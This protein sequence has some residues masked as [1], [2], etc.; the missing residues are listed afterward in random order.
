MCS[1]VGLRWPLV[2]CGCIIIFVFDSEGGSTVAVTV[3]LS[4]SVLTIA[5][6]DCAAAMMKEG[7][8]HIE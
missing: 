5:G 7:S 6:S 2:L 4:E 1:G 3:A 8:A